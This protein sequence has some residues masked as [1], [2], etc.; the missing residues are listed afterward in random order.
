MKSMRRLLVIIPLVALFILGSLPVVAAGKYTME[1]LQTIRN[2][3]KKRFD[4]RKVESGAL[5]GPARVP[6]GHYGTMEANAAEAERFLEETGD[7]TLEKFKNRPY[8]ID[9][10]VTW[11]K[12]ILDYFI[13]GQAKSGPAARVYQPLPAYQVSLPGPV[14]VPW[15][16][17]FLV[18]VNPS[19][20][21]SPLT[22]GGSSAGNTSNQFSLRVVYYDDMAG[23]RLSKEEARI[24]MLDKSFIAEH[25][26]ADAG[27]LDNVD[28]LEKAIKEFVENQLQG[29]YRAY[30][31][32]YRDAAYELLEDYKKNP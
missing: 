29:P 19:F 24:Y 6:I 3:V 13:E 26:S 31:N 9:E 5:V 25:I 11:G 12:K 2:E 15:G 10:Y 32:T 17:S 16:I 22:S 21:V 7:S 4:L 30:D 14:Y 28:S 18:P 1:D 23:K 27:L 8:E 20:R